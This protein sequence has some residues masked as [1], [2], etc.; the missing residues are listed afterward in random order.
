MTQTSKMKKYALI[1]LPFIVATLIMLPRLM[2]PQ[3]GFFDDARMLSQSQRFLQGDFSMSHDIQA[4]RFRPVYWLYYT[5]IY[6]LAGY[7]PFWFFFG[8]LILFYI[9]LIEIRQILK[10]MGVSGKQV[11]ISSLLFVL[12]MPIVENFYTLSKGEP[13]QLVFILA[14]IITYAAFIDS[15]KLPI[16]IVRMLGSTFF[17]VCGMMVKETTIV[18]LPIVFLWIAASLIINKEHFKSQK[19][20]MFSYLLSVGI[21]VLIF[22]VIRWLA[23]APPILGGTYTKNYTTTLSSFIPKILRWMT[24][25]AFNFH[26]L[27]PIILL[28]I[29][30]FFLTKRSHKAEFLQV[31]NSGI[32][33]LLWVLVLIPWQYAELY[34]LLPFACGSAI[35][36][37]QA[38]ALDPSIFRNKQ[39]GKNLQSIFFTI[40]GILF[41]LTIPNYLTHAKTQLLF[42]KIN[43]QV[44]D[45]VANE[46]PPDSQLFMNIQSSNEYS[47]KFQLYLIDHYN[48]EDI[49]Y[50]NLGEEQLAVIDQQSGAF[51]IMPFIEN[52]PRLTVRAGIEESYQTQWN[53]QT[54]SRLEN[55]HV[56]LQVFEDSIQI[57]NINLPVLACPIIGENGFCEQPDPFIDTRELTYGWKVLSVK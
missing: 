10:S 47:E 13:L 30:A 12:S 52:Q 24:Q 49:I 38:T 4:G 53:Q 54:L 16:K 5:F 41:I 17:I 20:L 43:R 35:L 23:G 18:M 25:L 40:A 57:F 37:R 11:L 26:Y 32:W 9:L 44:L 3:F 42:D 7:R 28:L 8:N 36:V 19:R 34:Y 27:L 14:S 55:Q 29:I 6:L 39:A 31:I 46:I 48:R 15:A 1:L 2:S 22:F 33:L 21:A 50:S 56:E 45:Y 51:I